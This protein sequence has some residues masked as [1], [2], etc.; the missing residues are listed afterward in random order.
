M[1]DTTLDAG[2]ENVIGIVR[3]LGRTLL[4]PAGLEADRSGQPIP[5]DHP[6]FLQF[7]QMG[8]TLGNMGVGKQS[9]RTKDGPSRVNRTAI[10]ASEELAY[11]DQGA[12]MSLPGP[13][14]GAPP[15]RILGTQDQKQ[16]FL[17]DP[18]SDPNRPAWG[19]YATTEAA[20]GSDVA[21]IQTTAI[22]DGDHYVLNGNKMFITNGARASWVVVFATTDPSLGRAGQR[23]FVVEKGTPG[24]TIGRIEKKM[25]LTA[26]ETA[27][28][29][30]ENCRVPAA[31]MLGTGKGKT[32]FKAAMSTFD[33]T[34]PMVAAMAVGI[35][36][37]AWDQ[38]AEIAKVAMSG[39]P[40]E[41]KMLDRLASA[42]R[43]LDAA[44]LLCWRAAWKMDYHQENTIDASMSKVYAPAAALYA[45][46]VAM[47]IAGLAGV[48]NNSLIE[49]CF[50][51]VK[52]FDIF[53]GTGEVQR[54]VLA[55]RLFGYP[56]S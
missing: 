44:R 41:Q 17:V 37:C 1:I 13:G 10:L 20:A 34:R 51:D 25:G 42:R 36:R 11:W 21:R 18:F 7:N 16:R 33:I 48:R 50:R 52:V 29:F 9:K 45:T 31:N 56:R 26:S 2:F 40:T 15:I 46:Q 6:M 30:Y 23:P 19:A 43:R 32:G 55:R 49:K 22:K 4:R 5:V 53:E 39:T 14:L 47:D 28:L 12:T 3:H 38:A 8:F 24:F 27:T 54:I 35:G